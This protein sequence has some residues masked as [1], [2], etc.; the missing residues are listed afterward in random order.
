MRHVA[1]GVLALAVMTIGVTVEAQGDVDCDGMYKGFIERMTRQ[2]R[3]RFTGERLASLHRRAQR[4]YDACRTGHL[5]NP[6][7]LFDVLERSSG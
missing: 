4:I 7:T 3:G 2:E 6:K 5:D 1:G